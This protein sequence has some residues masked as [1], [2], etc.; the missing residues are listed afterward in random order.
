MALRRLLGQPFRAVAGALE[1]PGNQGADTLAVE[2]GALDV[3][4]V[5]AALR[6]DPAFLEDGGAALHLAE[7]HI[8][9]RK[10]DASRPVRRATGN[11]YR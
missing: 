8:V 11:K 7:G 9:N 2:K 3:A 4:G 6:G 1:V 5:L 10:R